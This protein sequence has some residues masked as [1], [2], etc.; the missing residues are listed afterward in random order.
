MESK[1]MAIPVNLTEADDDLVL[2][3]AMPG[4]EPENI[5]ITV[6]EDAITLR[7]TARGRS[8]RDKKTLIEEWRIGEYHRVVKL[9]HPIDS[10]HVNVT[11]NNGVLTVSMPKSERTTPREINVRK[12]KGARGQTRGH[13]GRG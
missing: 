3:A 9:P 10:R 4:A 11:Y 8:A 5:S 1:F 12:V 7:A 2:H 13:S 6:T